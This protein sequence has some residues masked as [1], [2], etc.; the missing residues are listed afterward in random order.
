MWVDTF[1]E[2]ANESLRKELEELRAENAL[3]RRQ[4][5][6]AALLR[7][8]VRELKKESSEYKDATTTLVKAIGK[9][10]LKD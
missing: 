7:A 5:Q 10:V 4:M 1:Q 3:L 2:V 6:E 9:L 8:Q